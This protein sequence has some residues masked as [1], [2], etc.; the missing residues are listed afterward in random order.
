MA[1]KTILVVGTYDTKDAELRYLE[2]CI[3]GMGGSCWGP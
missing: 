1:D 3:R 2:A